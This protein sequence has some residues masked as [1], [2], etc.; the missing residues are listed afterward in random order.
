[1]AGRGTPRAGYIVRVCVEPIR[2]G[3]VTG[4]VWDVVVS[5]WLIYPGKKVR[6]PKIRPGIG[7]VSRQ[8]PQAP[9]RRRGYT[10]CGG[11]C[12]RVAGPRSMA[13]TSARRSSV[14]WTGRRRRATEADAWGE[15][16]E[17]DRVRFVML[18]KMWVADSMGL[19]PDHRE[20]TIATPSTMSWPED[21]ADWT[22]TRTMPTAD[23]WWLVRNVPSGGR[24]GIPV[25]CSA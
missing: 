22:L 12:Y 9:M 17:S 13:Q 3:L 8:T 11:A 24:E 7:R 1:V 15:S 6:A 14:V 5:V 20:C 25:A 4:W 23:G 16:L 18:W 2:V 21:T 19:W 10:A